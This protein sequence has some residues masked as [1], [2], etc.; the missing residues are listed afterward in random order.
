MKLGLALSGGAVRGAAHVGALMA[1]E[2][3]GIVPHCIAGTSIGALVGAL[4]AAGHRADDLA[5][6]FAEIGWPS[7]LG[8][9][10]RTALSLFDA[11]PMEHLLAERFG[12]TTFEALHTPFAAVACDIVSGHEVVMRAGDLVSAVRASCALPGVFPPVERSGQM[13]IDG[14]VLNNLP[15]DVARALGADFVLA[16]DL[17]PPWR[18]LGPPTNLLELWERSLTLLVQ[19][20]QPSRSAAD[21]PADLTVQPAIAA[22]SFSDF[23]GVDELIVL[24]RQA[25]EQALASAG[26]SA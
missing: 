15:I 17:L 11:G 14:G 8:P 7:L 21:H 18:A 6:A 20:N 13:L 16:V 26:L 22:F 12:L 10:L 19:G 23:G 5:L 9:N 2:N 3:A 4:S 25:T 24:G 1:L